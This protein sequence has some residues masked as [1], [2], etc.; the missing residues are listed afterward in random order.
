VGRIGIWELVAILAILVFIFGAKKLPEITR[1]VAESI[2][3]FKKSLN[4]KE[5]KS[6]DKEKDAS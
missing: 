4:F 5:N 3:E 6:E 1:S 2:K